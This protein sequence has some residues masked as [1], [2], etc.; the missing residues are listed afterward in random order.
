MRI[1]KTKDCKNKHLAKGLCRKC[2]DKIYRKQYK[3]DHK[4]EIIKYGKQRYENNR[5]K[6]LKQVKQ[7]NQDNRERIH[8]YKKQYR[9]KNKE[10]IAEQH[11][12]YTQTPIGKAIIKVNHIRHRTQDKDFIKETILRVYKDNI[13]KYGVLTCYLCGEPIVFGDKRLKDS[14]D[15]STP[16]IRKGSNK[17]GNLGIAHQ[18]CNNKK[19]TMTLGE[20]FN[21]KKVILW[22]RKLKK[23]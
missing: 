18:H 9:Y 15:H 14:I 22:K 12:K 1:C 3:Q 11:K 13:K 8:G 6:I 2:Y 4:C 21:N 10:Q 5:E 7:Y 23:L 16:V 19:H 20:W 17:Y